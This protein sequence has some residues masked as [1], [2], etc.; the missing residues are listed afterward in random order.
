MLE[1][2]STRQKSIGAVVVGVVVVILYMLIFYLPNKFVE[3][4]SG[5][6]YTDTLKVETINHKMIY[7]FYEDSITLE[8]NRVR[9]GDNFGSIL[10]KLEI[11]DSIIEEASKK[12]KAKFDL[13]KIRVGNNWTK[14]SSKPGTTNHSALVYEIDYTRYLLVFLGDTVSAS[15]GVKEV[16]SVNKTSIGSI[17]S[18]L[19]NALKENHTNPILASDMSDIFAWSVDFFG[20]EKGDSYKVVYDEDYVDGVSIGISEVTS[21]YFKH[22]GKDYYAFKYAENGTDFS[23]YDEEG[24][25]LKKAFLKA[26]LKFSRISSKFSRSRFHPVLKIFRP[27][28]GIDYSAPIGTPIFS[29]GDGTILAKGYDAKGGGNYIKIRHNSVYTTV[30]MHL[31][32]FES[33]L[34]V[35]NKVTQ[36]ETIGYVGKTGLATGP[37]LDFRVY[38]NGSPVN[39]LSIESPSVE[40]IKPENMEKYKLFIQQPLESIKSVP[41][42]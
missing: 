39:P 4:K 17:Y 8:V 32:K 40:P 31:S 24:K 34:S 25:S 18:S 22:K 38:M 10:H 9:N 26:P 16:I 3:D 29:I 41:V 15:I 6:D 7:G 20:I 14:I 11:A 42:K 30:Y 1:K 37:H 33:G 35:G 36:G 19:W 12:A 13:R 23:Y 28:H 5:L 2:F 27:H 21:A